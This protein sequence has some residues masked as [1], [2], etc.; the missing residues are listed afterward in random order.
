[1]QNDNPN[2]P[3]LTSQFGYNSFEVLINT[4]TGIENVIP[5]LMMDIS[6]YHANNAHHID[7]GIRAYHLTVLYDIQVEI[8]IEIL[9]IIYVFSFFKS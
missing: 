4:F 5:R 7:D 1:M 8:R 9:N 6:H 2:V 3:D